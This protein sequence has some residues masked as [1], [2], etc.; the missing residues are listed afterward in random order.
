MLLNLRHSC[1]RTGVEPLIGK[2]PDQTQNTVLILAGLESSL[3][4][5]IGPK[6]VPNIVYILLWKSE[7]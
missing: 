4:N 5:G 3:L 6:I 2:E 1:L 7:F